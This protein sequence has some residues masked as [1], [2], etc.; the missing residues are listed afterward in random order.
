MQF[1]YIGS[2]KCIINV[3]NN[4]FYST[5]HTDTAIESL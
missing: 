4:A 1:W 2:K 5:E 3:T